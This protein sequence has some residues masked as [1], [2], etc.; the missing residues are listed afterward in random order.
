MPGVPTVETARRGG[1]FSFGIL[2]YPSCTNAGNIKHTETGPLDN[3]QN[4]LDRGYPQFTRKTVRR[5]KICVL[6]RCFRS[7]Y[8]RYMSFKS[9]LYPAQILCLRTLDPSNRENFF[10]LRQTKKAYREYAD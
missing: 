9:A 4:Y 5:H 10:I 8:A 7:M 1:K 3:E 6:L 2:H